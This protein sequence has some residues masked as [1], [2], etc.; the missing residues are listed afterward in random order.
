[1]TEPADTRQVRP[2]RSYWCL[3]LVKCRVVVRPALPSLPLAE[4]G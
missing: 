1:M 3:F 2:A 4:T